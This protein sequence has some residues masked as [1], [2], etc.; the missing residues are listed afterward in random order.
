MLPP[1]SIED[2][3]MATGIPIT[4]HTEKSI[5]AIIQ[6]K[7]PYFPTKRAEVT[8]NYNSKISESEIL[9]PIFNE[10]IDLSNRKIKKQLYLNSLIFSDNLFALHSLI[11]QGI[12]VDLIYL[13][14]PYNT[15]FD[16]YSKDE[17]HAYRDNYDLSEYVEFMRIRLIL[18]REILSDFGSIYIHIG[19]QMLPYLKVIM[20]E[21]FGIKNCRNI[22]TR[23]KCSSKNYTK[24]Q[25]PN[26][27]DFILFYSKTDKFIWNPQG[28]KPT[29]DW[30]KKEYPKSD[31]KGQFKL[32][33]IHAPGIRNGET[34]KEWRGLLPPKG[35]HWQYTP[36]KLD[37][38]DR[39]GDIVWSKTGNPR[40]KVYLTD[41][42]L[43]PLSDYWDCFRDAHHQS[44]K[45]TGYPTEKNLAMLE[46]IVKS[47]SNSDSVVLDPFCGSGT[48]LEAATKQGRKFIGI[49]QSLNAIMHSYHRLNEVFSRFQ[50]L[51]DKDVYL[52]FQSE[53]EQALFR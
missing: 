4:T 14:P 40:R 44:I 16:F 20:D 22:I 3:L 39:Q 30:I 1:T 46:M 2:L 23:K 5:S 51:C 31:E 29:E 32:V 17:N 48:T 35:K 25:F 10:Y 19:H 33:P 50:L 47:S 15:G 53:I 37:E 52:S 45:T 27:N 42:K 26:L 7:L 36:D 38:L 9:K 21:I 18:L 12:K 34:G 49:D 8:L 41:D 24:N 6:S 11:N 43:I 28:S 13:D